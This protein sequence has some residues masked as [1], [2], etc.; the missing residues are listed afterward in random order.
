MI[1]WS[2]TIWC[3]K[4]G[5]ADNTIDEP[6]VEKIMEDF[7]SVSA[8]PNSREDNW[9]ICM[10]LNYLSRERPSGVM[11][12]FLVTT[13]VQPDSYDICKIPAAKFLKI[14]MCDETARVLGHEPWEGGIPPY[15]WIGE[16]TRNPAPSA[17]NAPIPTAPAG[18]RSGCFP[19]WRATASYQ[20][21]ELTSIVTC[22]FP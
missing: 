1:E 22:M 16:Q 8:L 4:V 10:S 18:I 19:V 14:R 2:D 17:K 9:D 12:G 11:F 13:D 3:G 15:Q 21:R 6:N 5:Y 7:M 20:R